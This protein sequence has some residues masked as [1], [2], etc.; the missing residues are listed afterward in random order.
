MKVFWHALALVA[1]LVLAPVTA[2][3]ELAEN[4]ATLVMRDRGHLSLTMYVRYTEAVHGAVA[5][6][7]NYWQ[8]LVAVS[9]L[10]PADFE[11]QMR[12]AHEALQAGT[13]LYLDGKAPSGFTNWV[14]PEPATAQRLFQQR[15][16]DATVG[17][18]AHHHEEPIEVHADGVLASD[19]PN[20]RVMFSGALGKVLVVWYRPRQ[21]WVDAGERSRPIN[22]D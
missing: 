3:H 21:A 9:S 4:R 20:V 7:T 5:P 13:R 16:M 11:K 6:A 22:F 2:A 17:G 14:W 19:V 1:T 15:L 10:P 8:Y 12:R 18:G